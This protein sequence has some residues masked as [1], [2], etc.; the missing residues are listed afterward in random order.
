MAR[1]RLAKNRGL[2]P[3][4]YQ[5]TAGYFYYVNPRNKE[6][7]GLGRDKAKACAQARAA[8]AVLATMKE[9]SLA[10]WVAGTASISLSEWVPQ[11]KKLWEEKTNPAG[12]TLRNA[13]TYLRKIEAA[14]FAWMKLKDIGTAHVAQF[15][16]AAEKASGAASAIALRSRLQDVFRMAET[17]GLVEQGRNPVDATYIPSRE[18]MRERLTLEQFYAIRDKAPLYLKRAMNL[19]LVTGQR[20]DDI[21]NLKFS[22]VKDGYLFV[23]QGKSQG[24]VKLQLDTRIRLSKVNMSIGEAIQDCRDLIVS[25][26]LI[27]HVEHVASVKPGDQV[28]ANGLSNTFQRAREAAGITASEGRTPPSFH[29]IRSLAQRLYREEYGAAFAQ[30]MLG[31]KNET[32]TAKYNDL[33]GSAFQLIAAK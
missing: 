5:N 21:T 29:E 1:Q 15:I 4:L 19:A 22:D 8:N 16:E 26:Y 27:H 6:T 7:K 2:P 23:V 17:R 18:V 32:M 20:R 14:D 31:H 28:P 3:N 10:D 12:N 24:A 9:N 30:A 13:S 11:Y 25:R 33:R